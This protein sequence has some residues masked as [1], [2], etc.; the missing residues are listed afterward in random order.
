MRYNNKARTHNNYRG[1]KMLIRYSF[2]NFRSFRDE[3]E[4]CMKAT[5]QTTLNQNLIRISGERLLPS[6]VIY[7]AN[8]S[9]KSNIILSLK[10]LRKIIVCGSISVP[11]VDLNDLELC[12]FIHDSKN[13]PISFEIEFINN[14]K[15]C[16]YKLDIQV[17]KGK[18]GNRTILNEEFYIKRSRKT[19]LIYRRNKNRID[20][21]TERS[22]LKHMESDA[23]FIESITKKLTSNMDNS[24]P[25]L[26]SG[27]KNIINNDLAN[28][29]ISFFSEKLI[30]IDNF[31]MTASNVQ[32][33]SNQ[34]IKKDFT[35]WNRILDGFVKGADFGPQHM[36]FKPDVDD[37]DEH[38]ADMQL[39]S[40]Y[41]IGSQNMLIPAQLMESGGTLKLIDFA[42]LFQSFF[43]S[44]CVFLMD[45]FDAS[46]HPEIIKGILALFHDPEFNAE[47]SQ[48]IF[49]THNPIYLNNKIFRRDQISFV[50]KD[51]TNF[52]SSLYTLADFGSTDV[53]NDENYLIN[54]FKGKYASLPYIDFSSMFREEE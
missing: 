47:G 11:D 44:G 37:N 28:C 15:H 53:R 5:S 6:I 31:T 7:G 50:E 23:E 20:I 42:L 51:R 45:E 43:P 39:F 18:K 48:L 52:R 2:G 30:I 24:V 1:D 40:V 33:K 4:V 3:A 29:V 46:L 14:S 36:I 25:F 19:Q 32:L 10:I 27:F 13:R 35:M 22:A 41:H 34:I 21:S 38:T 49:T 26:T 16:I 9:G 8:A 54:Y 12:P 17:D